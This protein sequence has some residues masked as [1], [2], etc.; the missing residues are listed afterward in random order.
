MFRLKPLCLQSLCLNTLCLASLSLISF[1]VAQ[2]ALAADDHWQFTLPSQ[3]GDRF[4]SLAELPGPVLVNFWGVDCPPCI[5][6]LPMLGTYARLHTDWQVLLVN[7]DG[8]AP[9]Q[10]FLEQHPLPEMATLTLLRPGLNVSGLMRKAGNL[11]G[12]LPFSVAVDSRH[13]ICFRK[14]GALTEDDLARMRHGC[15]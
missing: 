4:V 15:R 11:H 13:R 12:V 7:T 6:E 2:P 5:S 8:A 9:T 14:A 10:R 1:M 3:D